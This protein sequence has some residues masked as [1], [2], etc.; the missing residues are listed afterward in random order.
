M[1]EC[2]AVHSRRPIPGG[3]C[4]PRR[5][6]SNSGTRLSTLSSGVDGSGASR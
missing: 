1:K 5:T 4:Q 6:G 3:A 2:E